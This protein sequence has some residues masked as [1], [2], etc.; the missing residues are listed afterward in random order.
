MTTVSASLAPPL[1]PGD[2]AELHDPQAIT[3]GAMALRGVGFPADA[4]ILAAF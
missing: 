2:P 4:E 3:D 1:N